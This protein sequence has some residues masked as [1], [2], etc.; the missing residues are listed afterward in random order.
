MSEEIFS[1]IRAIEGEA[2]ALL[3]QART[4]ARDI[5]EDAKKQSRVIN[6]EEFQAG[7]TQQEHDKIVQEAKKKAQDLIEEAK[8]ETERIKKQFDSNVDAVVEMI[9]NHIYGNA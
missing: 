4:K 6:A 3:S 1:T 7:E 9:V 2:E 8:G 5:L